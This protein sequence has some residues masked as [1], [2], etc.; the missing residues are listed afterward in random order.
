MK[1]EVST[2]IKLYN[3][4]LNNCR[5]YDSELMNDRLLNEIGVLRGLSYALSTFHVCTHDN[6]FSKFIKM[7]ETLCRED[8]YRR[9]NQ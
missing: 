4:T 9:E 7:Q 2:L 6:E 1:K 3:R 8:D 5:F